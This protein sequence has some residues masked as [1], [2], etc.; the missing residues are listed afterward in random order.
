MIGKFNRLTGLSWARIKT[1]FKSC[2]E[3]IL[4]FIDVLCSV[5]SS[6]KAFVQESWKLETNDIVV[7]IADSSLEDNYALH[8]STLSCMLDT[9]FVLICVNSSRFYVS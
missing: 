3:Q 1:G 4:M 9:S 6:G 2:F 8:F 5:R 7:K